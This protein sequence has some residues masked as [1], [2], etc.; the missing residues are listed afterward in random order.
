MV[1]AIILKLMGFAGSAMEKI[2]QSGIYKRFKELGTLIG[3][4]RIDTYSAGAAFYIFMSFIPYLLIVLSTIKYLPFSKQD[5]L[6][7]LDEL[8]PVDTNGMIVSMIDEMYERG[9]GILSVSIIAAI[10]ASAKGVLG[11]T[12]G[13]NEIYEATITKNFLYM[14]TRSAICT[15]LLMLGMILMLVI[16]VF[17]STIIGLI[18]NRIDIP[19]TLLKLI[20]ARDIIMWFVLFIVFMFFFCVLPA[21]KIKIRSQFIGALSSSLVWIVFT[22]LFSFY[23]SSLHGYSMYGS[24]AVLLVIGVWLY[25]GMYIMFMGALLNELLERKERIGS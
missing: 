5:L 19:Q 6:V 16:S 24:F 10:W 9:I 22:R 20:N 1:Y 14:R 17:G 18:E 21:K 2:R 13:L 25:A 7:F 4:K 8:L 23:V 15:L 12:K 3:D 11:I